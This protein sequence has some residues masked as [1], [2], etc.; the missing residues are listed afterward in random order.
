M[1]NADNWYDPRELRALAVRASSGLVA[2]ES[3]S[4]ARQSGIERER[5]LRYALLDIAA[6]ETLTRIVEKP[7][8]EDPLA[9]ASERWVSMNLWSFTPAIF[10]AC[11]RVKPSPR[12]ELEL[13]DAVMIAIRELGVTF[14]VVRSHS[15]VLDLSSRADV[16]FVAQR[17]A[18]APSAY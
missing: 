16:A 3:E 12:G 5:I 4:L 13:Q 2:Y 18:S 10:E 6:N 8:A 11:Q 17:L 9:R 1:L 14:S 15:G 7:A